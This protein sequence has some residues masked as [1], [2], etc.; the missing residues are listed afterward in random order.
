M[1]A[2]PISIG[3]H[4]FPAKSAAASFASEIL[5]RIVLGERIT[6]EDEKVVRDLFYMHPDSA[7]KLDGHEISHFEVA[8]QPEQHKVTRSFIV[9]R[10]DGKR[11]DFSF[12]RALKIRR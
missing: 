5:N 10:S 3:S 9:V 12:R 2:I 4:R 6:G 8:D 1:T 11:E 7:Q